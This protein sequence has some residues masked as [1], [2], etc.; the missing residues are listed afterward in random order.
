[1]HEGL[2]FALFLQNTFGKAFVLGQ[3][4]CAHVTTN[5]YMSLYLI[6]AHTNSA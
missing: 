3:I 4:M 5:M 6:Q 1:M 2:V